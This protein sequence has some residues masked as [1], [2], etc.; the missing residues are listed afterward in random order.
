MR[1]TGFVKNQLDPEEAT[2]TAVLKE[3]LR[4]SRT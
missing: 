1:F 3:T 4:D 2:S